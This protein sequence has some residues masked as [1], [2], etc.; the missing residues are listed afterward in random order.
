MHAP[1]GAGVAPG[2]GCACGYGFLTPY[3]I[4]SQQL[5]LS[6][7]LYFIE[8]SMCVYVIVYVSTPAPRAGPA[9]VRGL[10]RVSAVQGTLQSRERRQTVRTRDATSSDERSEAGPRSQSQERRDRGVW[11]AGRLCVLE[12]TSKTRENERDESRDSAHVF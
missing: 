2:G 6:S 11:R 4:F 9:G 7:V 3:L 5:I 12:A 10:V 8:F 1:G